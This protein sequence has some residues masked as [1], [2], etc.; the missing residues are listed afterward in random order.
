MTRLARYKITKQAQS[1]STVKKDI[2]DIYKKG[3]TPVLSNAGNEQ[4]VYSPKRQHKGSIPGTSAG[5][6]G[7]N[8]NDSKYLWN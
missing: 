1:S 7:K 6:N 5:T 8:V 3:E 2:P 4:N